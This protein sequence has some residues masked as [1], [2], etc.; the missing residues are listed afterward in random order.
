MHFGIGKNF[1]FVYFVCFSLI[2][3]AASSGKLDVMKLLI[4]EGAEIDAKDKCNF[5]PL[6]RAVVK[7]QTKAVKLLLSHNASLLIE[8]DDLKSPIHF[9]V[10]QGNL[11]M[12]SVLI[13]YQGTS[14]IHSKDAENQTALHYAAYY[15]HL[16]VRMR[17]HPLDAF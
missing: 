14:Q 17:Q 9:A 10:E 15:G 7:G 2:F 4:S 6:F 12:L 8:D 11:E 1:D 3:R 16:E 13:A 5:T